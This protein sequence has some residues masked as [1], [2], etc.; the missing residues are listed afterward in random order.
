[1]IANGRDDALSRID[2]SSGDR[3]PLRTG[4]SP[5]V[6]RADGGTVWIASGQPVPAPAPLAD[7]NEVRVALTG[8]VLRHG[9]RDVGRP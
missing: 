7:G 8:D 4:S 9:S 3:Q 1:M 2:L 5:M 6:V